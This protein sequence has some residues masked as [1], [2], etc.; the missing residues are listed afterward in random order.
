MDVTAHGAEVVEAGA[1]TGRDRRWVAAVVAAV[2]GYAA[3]AWWGLPERGERAGAPARPVVPL[4]EQDGP[5]PGTPL[6]L[7]GWQVSYRGSPPSG[8]TVECVLVQ[9]LQRPPDSPGGVAGAVVTPERPR[10]VLPDPAGRAAALVTCRDGSGEVVSVRVRPRGH[11]STGAAGPGV[12]VSEL[13]VDVDRLD[14]LAAVVTAAL[15]LSYTPVVH[16]V[17][18]PLGGYDVRADEAGGLVRIPAEIADAP[19]IAEPLV[20][21]G[22]LLATLRDAAAR[23]HPRWHEVVAA[24]APLHRDERVT[25]AGRVL[26]LATYAGRA[27]L[28]TD[29]GELAASALTVLKHYGDRVVRALGRL[30][31]ADRAA[32]RRYVAAVVR[33]VAGDD[34]A[35]RAELRRLVPALDRLGVR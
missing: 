18:S 16:L 33:V 28:R 21:H 3:G 34:P 29:P 31:P 25:A 19:G 27:D 2:L 30:A 6:R 4:V 5:L 10:R 24:F 35:Q 1:G 15:P 20:F 8:E 26:W 23:F 11:V 9:P 22:V 14:A 7:T 12:V 17:D 32:V 13:P